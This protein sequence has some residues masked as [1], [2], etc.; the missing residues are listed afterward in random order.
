[1]RHYW[2]SS[3]RGS[4]HLQVQGE[5]DQGLSSLPCN[6]HNRLSSW[7]LVDLKCYQAAVV[8][9]SRRSKDSKS[10]YKPTKWQK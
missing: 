6:S 4:F 5:G 10:L 9:G 8:F 1:M 7:A 3:R 2:L